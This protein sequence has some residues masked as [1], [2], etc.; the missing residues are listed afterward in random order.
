MEFSKDIN[1]LSTKNYKIS[2][3]NNNLAVIIR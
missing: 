1:S 2:D 3:F